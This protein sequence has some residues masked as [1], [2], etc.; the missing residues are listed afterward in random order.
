MEP[1]DKFWAAL[2]A[3]TYAETQEVAITLRDL[4]DNE[5]DLKDSV[6]WM[7]L[8]NDAREAHEREAEE[9]V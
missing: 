5:Y 8:L 4:Y 1:I 3:L 9:A 7:A 2:G 6:G